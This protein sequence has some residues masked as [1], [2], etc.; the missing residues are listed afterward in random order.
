[1]D[2]LIFRIRGIRILLQIDASTGKDC[3]F[4]GGNDPSTEEFLR[5]R[6]IFKENSLC[7]SQRQLIEHGYK[8]RKPFSLKRSPQALH[9]GTVWN[10]RY[11]AGESTI[12][13]GF[14]GI[15]NHQ[16]GLF[17]SQQPLI[18]MKQRVLQIP[19]KPLTKNVASTMGRNMKLSVGQVMR[20]GIAIWKISHNG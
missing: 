3:R 19:L 5:I 2:S 18:C 17:I 20:M 9:I 16:I 10:S 1:M 4:L 13:V 12:N 11:C 6:F 7:L 15:C 8:L 14:D